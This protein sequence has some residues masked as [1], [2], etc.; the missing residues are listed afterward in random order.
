[1][2]RQIPKIRTSQALGKWRQGRALEHI[3]PTGKEEALIF[4]QQASH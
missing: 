3:D 1:M 2:Y 4:S